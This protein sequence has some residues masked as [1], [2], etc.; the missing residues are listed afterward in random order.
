MRVIAVTVLAAALAGCAGAKFKQNMETSGARLDE[1]SQYQLRNVSLTPSDHP[2]ADQAMS[3]CGGG[4]VSVRA[5]VLEKMEEELSGRSTSTSPILVAKRK[6]EDAEE[7]LSSCAQ[8][9]GVLMWAMMEG[10]GTAQPLKTSEWLRQNRSALLSFRLASSNLRQHQAKMR[11]LQTA[12]GMGL[13]S[14]S[15]NYGNPPRYQYINPYMRSDGTMVEGHLRT[16]PNDYC[17]DNLN[18]C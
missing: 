7:W 11:G 12:I 10:P 8:R 3:Y 4:F 6:M 5:N 2:R 13:M 17:F 16:T 18:G 15:L 1:L 14:G 9:Y